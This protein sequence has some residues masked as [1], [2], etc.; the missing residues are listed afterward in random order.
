MKKFAMIGYYH[1]LEGGV[2]AVGNVG[3]FAADPPSG[4]RG[5]VI[6]GV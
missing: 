3:D 1:D 4:N 5:Y 2:Y 6:F